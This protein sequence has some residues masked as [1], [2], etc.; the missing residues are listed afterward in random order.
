MVWYA[1]ELIYCREPAVTVDEALDVRVDILR[2]TMLYDGRH[3]GIRLDPPN[4]EWEDLKARL[5]SILLRHAHDEDTSALEDACLLVLWPLVEPMLEDAFSRSRE[6]STG[7]FDCWRFAYK[8]EPDPAID[9]H[10]ANAYAPES[11]FTPQNRRRVLTSLRDLLLE[12]SRQHPEAR[13][14]QCFS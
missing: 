3:P 13:S 9:L 7:P 11:P 10:F 2:K 5:A 1:R 8:D 14:V 6:F 12:A 4:A